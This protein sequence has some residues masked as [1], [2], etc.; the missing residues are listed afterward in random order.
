MSDYSFML[1]S[2]ICILL[3]NGGSKKLDSYVAGQSAGSLCCSSIS[4]AEISVGYGGKVMSDPALA[5][6]L[7]A[8]P[9]VEFNEAA[10]Y[11][12]GMLPFRRARFDRLIAAHALALGVPLVTNNGS[13]FA[14]IPGLVIQNWLSL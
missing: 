5:A 1:D 8:I 10:A 3:L 7:A 14:D 11:Q 9:P 13:D 4:L 2:D 6:F 12:Y